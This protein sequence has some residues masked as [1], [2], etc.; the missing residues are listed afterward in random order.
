MVTDVD[1]DN[2]TR[3]D[4]LSGT[5]PPRGTARHR[6]DAD[7]N[8]TTRTTQESKNGDTELREENEPGEEQN[9]YEKE[10]MAFKR[11]LKEKAARVM[12]VEVLDEEMNMM[13]ERLAVLRIATKY[14]NLWIRQL[15]MKKMEVSELAGLMNL[16]ETRKEIESE[17]SL[18]RWAKSFT[19]SFTKKVKRTLFEEIDSMVWSGNDEDISRW[20]RR[21]KVYDE[22]TDAEIEEIW[23]NKTPDNDEP[24]SPIPII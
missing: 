3:M 19:H 2:V 8:S 6:T 9:E 15:E 12:K 1:D 10:G 4:F 5:N 24:W 11:R 13:V 14:I 18:K 16:D 7:V 20:C 23:K 21:N 22:I 17:K